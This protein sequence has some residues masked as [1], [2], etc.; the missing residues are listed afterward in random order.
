MVEKGCSRSY[1]LMVPPPGVLKGTSGDLGPSRE[2]E[3]RERR[4]WC[5]DGLRAHDRAATRLP[6]GDLY[7]FDV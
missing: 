3:V 7:A 2:A 1:M 4:G 5:H 6:I